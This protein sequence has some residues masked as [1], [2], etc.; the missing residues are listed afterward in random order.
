V[1]P[2][3]FG[4][5]VGVPNSINKEVVTLIFNARPA[6]FAAR[7]ATLA[8]SL[9]VLPFY[10]PV[11]ISA[12]RLSDPDA[13]LEAYSALWHID[14]V[15]HA[16][17]TSDILVGEDG[18][19][20]FTEADV[21]YDGVEIDIGTPP[22]RSINVRATVQWTQQASGVIDIGNKN[23][24]T[25]T[26]ASLLQGW[27]KAGD[28]IGEG[29][30][31]NTASAIDVYDVENTPVASFSSTYQNQAKRH[32][33]GDVLSLNKSSSMPVFKGPYLSC[34]LLR[35]T[36]TGVLDP[37]DPLTETFGANDPINIPAKVEV[38]HFFVPLWQINTTLSIRYDAERA[39]DETISFTLNANVQPLVTLPGEEEAMEMKLSSVDVGLEIPGYG[40]P[41]ASLGASNYLPS[42][43]GQQSVQYLIALAR[44]NLLLRARAVRITFPCRFTRAIDL[45]CRKTARIHDH[46]LP[47]GSAVGK[48]T[49]YSFSADGDKGELIGSV[50]IGCAIGYGGAVGAVSGT[51]DY[52]EDGYV[53]DGY[54]TRTGTIVALPSGDVGFTPP[55][56]ERS[57]DDGL[58]FPLDRFQVVI[59]DQMNGSIDVQRRAILTAF[60]NEQIAAEIS[61]LPDKTVE[62]QME[63]ARVNKG[64]TEEVLKTNAIWYQL[65]LKPV[66]G[67]FSV[68]YTLDPT[69]LEIPRQIDLEASSSP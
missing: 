28:D 2:L 13:V 67:E 62:M 7:K 38:S 9:K 14:R 20:E 43:R 6:D 11:W 12:D 59:A 58:Q 57:M 44:S 33:N 69:V 10:D 47:G 54:Q 4:R 35:K 37:G 24:A 3:F 40:R 53:E 18:L 52:V 17:T 1:V 19:A 21:F 65:R 29:W 61:D 8:E 27:P 30:S 46:R 68:P 66:T 31:V 60:T 22:V 55:R 50:S 64:K 32:N 23:V 42:T 26:G 16:V 36:Q 41:L 56:F 63:L 15:T 51:P 45:S 34:E 48:I 25:Y 49:S 5:L 39:R